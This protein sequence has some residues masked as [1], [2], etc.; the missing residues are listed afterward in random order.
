MGSL[1]IAARTS[2]LT[3]HSPFRIIDLGLFLTLILCYRSIFPNNLELLLSYISLGL[4]LLYFSL[5]LLFS[6]ISLGLLLSNNLFRITSLIH[7]FM[8]TLDRIVA[9]FSRVSTSFLFLQNYSFSNIFFSNPVLRL[10]LPYTI[11]GFPLPYHVFMISYFSP[12]A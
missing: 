2:F 6:Y 1:I 8:V 5:G 7:F 12:T 10:K 9:L 4:F 11:L 3:L